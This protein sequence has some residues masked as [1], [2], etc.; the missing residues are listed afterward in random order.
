L[1]N[2]TVCTLAGLVFLALTSVVAYHFGGPYLLAALWALV[3][4]VVSYAFS[5]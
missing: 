4:L 2:D 5:S 1:R 3:A